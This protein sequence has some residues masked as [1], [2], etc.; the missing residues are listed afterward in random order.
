MGYLIERKK[1]D[2]TGFVHPVVEFE[3]WEKVGDEL[4]E[5]SAREVAI[6]TAMHIQ[7][8]TYRV[9]DIYSGKVLFNIST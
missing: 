2:G 6:A 8:G 5:Q 1:T 4:S 9:R 7:K 3:S